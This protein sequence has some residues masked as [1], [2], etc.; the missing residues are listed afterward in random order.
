MTAFRR[1]IAAALAA[2][3]LA[4][5]APPAPAD[6]AVATFAGGCFWCMEPPYDDIE[7][8]LATTSGYMGGHVEDPTY[9]QVTAGGTGHAEVVQVTYD[10]E[11]VSYERL[12]AI[13][14]RNVDPFDADGQFC[15]RGD[16]YRPE[17]FVHSA[18]Q[19][20][21]AEASRAEL[22][23]RFE[24][25]IVVP[26]T[27]AGEFYAAEDYHQNYYQEHPIRYRVYRRLCGRDGRLEEIWTDGKALDP[28]FL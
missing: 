17:I 18:E 12:L 6:E 4:A 11:R 24:R 5:V 26:V 15:D 8:V 20:R 3:G 23:T 22:Q 28:A 9:E 7:G 2:L 16:S 13:Y 27:E 21:L 1:T 10:P 25:E 19:R 14:W